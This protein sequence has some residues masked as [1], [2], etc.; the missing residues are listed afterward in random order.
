M[1]KLIFTFHNS[2]I[3][4]KKAVLLIGTTPEGQQCNFGVNIIILLFCFIHNSVRSATC[5]SHGSILALARGLM[6]RNIFLSCPPEDLNMT[7]FYN[8]IYVL[9]TIIMKYKFKLQML[10]FIVLFATRL[11]CL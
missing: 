4:T 2:A 8:V 1:M 10:C 11:C 6:S 7:R 9:Q 3:M 5:K